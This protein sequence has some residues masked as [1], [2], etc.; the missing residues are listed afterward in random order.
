MAYSS[1]FYSQDLLDAAEYFQVAQLKTLCGVQLTRQV[2]VNSSDADPHPHRSAFNAAPG[3]ES[4]SGF[5]MWIRI[6][7]P[8]KKCIAES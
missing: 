4:G 3:F 5:R 2:I 8:K 7:L 1:S 6:Q